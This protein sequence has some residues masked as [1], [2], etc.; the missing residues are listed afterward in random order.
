MTTIFWGALDRSVTNS[1]D[2]DSAIAQALLD[3]QYFKTISVWGLLAKSA[4]D[5]E[6]IEEAINRLIAVH[7]ADATAHVGAGESLE[8]HKNSDVIDHVIGSVVADK[9]TMSEI[10]VYTDFGSLAGWTPTG[11]YDIGFYPG[12]RLGSDYP[13]ANG[14]RLNSVEGFAEQVFNLSKDFLIEWSGL[15]SDSNYSTFF[16]GLANADYP[17]SGDTMV[18][19]KLINGVIKGVFGKGATFYQTSAFTGDISTPNLYR[20]QYNA[21]TKIFSFYVNGSLLGS[22]DASAE[23]GTAICYF[24]LSLKE[25]QENFVTIYVYYFRASRKV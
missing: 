19:F 24:R 4:I 2:I 23:S 18:G 7:E 20:V 13:S 25:I 3:Y 11:D 14:T 22:Y 12:I 21:T 17:A 15:I 6:T 16:I 9:L 8:S 5:D 10:D 1:Q